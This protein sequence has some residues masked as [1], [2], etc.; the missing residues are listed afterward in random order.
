MGGRRDRPVPRHHDAGQAH[1]PDRSRRSSATT[2]CSSTRP[3]R[4]A[5]SPSRRTATAG[6]CSSTP[7]AR[8]KAPTTTAPP[9]RC[10][11]AESFGGM[12]FGKMTL[13][14]ISGEIVHT[15]LAA[16]ER[17][18]FEA[19]WAAAKERLGREP[20]ILDLDRTPGPAP[21][22]RARRDGHP[23]PH[24]PRRRPPPRARCSRCWSA[25][26]RSPDRCSSSST[27]PSSP[28]A[29]WPPGSPKP[30][31]SASCSRA[32]H[33]C[34]DVGAERRF[35]RGALKH[36][37]ELRDRTCFHPSCD[38]P[39]IYPQIDHI[40]EASQGRPHHPGQ[41]PPRLRL[42]QPLAQPP[43]RRG[44]GPRHPRHR[45]PRR[46]PRPTFHLSSADPVRGWSRIKAR[47]LAP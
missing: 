5:S 17:E 1:R 18:L 42:P 37:I 15:T 28:R 34:I 46:R 4:S 21:R 20:T 30:T 12:W 45:R 36:A 23:R 11:S 9:A 27:A 44:V 6:S 3:A 24:R 41:R 14:P 22:R 19:D 7:T 40:E 10:T 43:P 26:R 35:F 32:R 47:G 31:S 8:S 16:I 33:G 13:D 25:T 38:E 29:R 39:P 2:R